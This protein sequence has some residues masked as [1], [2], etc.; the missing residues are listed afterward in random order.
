M[1]RIR[2][3]GKRLRNRPLVAFAL[4]V[5]RKYS[6]D[7]GPILTASVAYYGFFS[8]L[9]LLL[10]LTTVLGFALRHHPHLQHA[11]V[12]SALG[13]LPVVGGELR[14]RSLQGS[15]LALVIGLGA[16]L[17]AGIGSVLGAEAALNTIWGIPRSERPGFLQSRARAL[18]L[19]LVL[20]GGI[21]AATA[22]AG[23]GT[24]GARYGIAWKLAS[25]ALSTVLDLTLFLVAF[26]LLIGDEVGW[27]TLAPGAIAAAIGYEILQLVGGYYIGHVVKHASEAYGTFALVLGLLS[28]IHVAVLVMLLAVEAN[29]VFAR[30]AVPAAPSRADAS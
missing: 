11:I 19:L 26:R 3:R 10:V 6:D 14:T 15:T 18:V 23:V 7:Q 21:L 22:L 17:W 16:A 20:G 12:R 28:F 4:A 24:V 2:E 30:G 27:K 29:V 8:V 1:S 25:V 9:P 13:Q 5:W